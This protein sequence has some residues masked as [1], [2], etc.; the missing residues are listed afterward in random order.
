MF[1]KNIHYF[2]QFNEKIALIKKNKIK[3]K[4][5]YEK[6]NQKKVVA[7]TQQVQKDVENN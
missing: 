3:K 7:Q 4:E 1:V 2:L 6:M 5:F